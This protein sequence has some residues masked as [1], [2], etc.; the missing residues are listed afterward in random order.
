MAGRKGQDA[1]RGLDRFPINW[2]YGTLFR[3]RQRVTVDDEPGVVEMCWA[4]PTP[5]GGW[6]FRY[7]VRAGTRRT[8]VSEDDIDAE[9][10]GEE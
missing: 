8:E 1:G 9:A 7:C 5:G 10:E 3:W 4:V 2:P 6:E